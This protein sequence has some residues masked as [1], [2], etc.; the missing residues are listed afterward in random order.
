M[1]Y[2]DAA[3][4]RAMTVQ[5]AMLKA[6]SGEP[7]RGTRTLMRVARLRTYSVGLRLVLPLVAR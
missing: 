1:G 7:R 3:R 6:L 2:P 5:E 4:E